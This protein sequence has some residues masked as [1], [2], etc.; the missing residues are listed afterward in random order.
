MA[1][2]TKLPTGGAAPRASS[3]AI[4]SVLP[5]TLALCSSGG[6]LSAMTTPALLAASLPARS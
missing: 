5:V 4:V 2:T 3:N 1:F 6:R